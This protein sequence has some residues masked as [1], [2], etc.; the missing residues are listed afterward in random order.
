MRII[1]IRHG[2][3]HI[4]LRPRTGHVGFADYVGAYEESGLAPSDLPPQE[5][6]DLVKELDH[7]FTSDRPRSR[8]SAAALAPHARLIADPLF[9]EAP[10][11]APRV[12]SMVVAA[13][14][15]SS[16]VAAD[17]VEETIEVEEVEELLSEPP[18]P[19]EPPSRKTALPP[20]PPR[21]QK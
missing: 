9:T 3:P 21:F 20:A 12:P 17:D 19:P 13:E 2:Q 14:P 5:L 1:L 16:A 8:Q 4:E 7:V 10:L 11:A 15:D 18:A 6:R